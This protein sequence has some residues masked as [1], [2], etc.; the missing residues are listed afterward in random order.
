MID[1]QTNGQTPNRCFTLIAMNATSVKML[2]DV[3]LLAQLKPNGQT[4]PNFY[5]FC[6]WPWLSPLLTALRYLV[7][8]GFVDDVVVLHITVL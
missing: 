7:D 2:C 3:Y 6:L 1:G 8:S 5:V 4:S